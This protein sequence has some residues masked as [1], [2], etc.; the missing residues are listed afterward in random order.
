[1]NSSDARIREHA[2][3]LVRTFHEAHADDLCAAT[4]QATLD[5]LRAHA[6][7]SSLPALAHTVACDACATLAS[8]H[9]TVAVRPSLCSRLVPNAPVITG[10]PESADATVVAR[11]WCGCH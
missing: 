6:S 10:P 2:S 4:S 8:R 5:A 1:M 7:D 3:A 11:Q 9:V